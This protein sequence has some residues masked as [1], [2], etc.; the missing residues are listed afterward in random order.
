MKFL[1][2]FSADMAGAFSFGFKGERGVASSAAVLGAGS[3]T[4]GYNVYQCLRCMFS[5]VIK[6]KAEV[7]DLMVC[8]W[9][10]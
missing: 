5:L 6:N 8:L 4:E 1:P 9:I 2:R 10:S 3:V 7:I